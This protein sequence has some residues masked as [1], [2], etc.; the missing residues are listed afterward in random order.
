MQA[1]KDSRKTR[2]ASKKKPGKSEGKWSNL[3]ITEKHNTARRIAGILARGKASRERI[4][5]VETYSFNG[6]LVVGLSGHVVE[7]DFPAD[8]NNWQKIELRDLIHAK[9][10]VNPTQS[11]IVSVIRKLGREA[12]RVT[13]ATDFDREGELIG[14]E[15]LNIIREVNPDVKVERVRYSAIT[16]SEIERAFRNPCEVD[17]NLAAAAESRQI[18]DLVWGAVLTRFISLAAGRLGDKFLSVGR[19]QSPTLALLVK[20]EKERLAFKPEPYWEIYADLKKTGGGEF[21]AQH[22]QGRFKDQETA[23]SVL[24]KLGD[25]AVVTSIKKGQRTDQVPVPFNT[26]EFLR[27]ASSIGFSAANAMRIAESL[28]VNGYIS[29]PR[30]DNTVY[31]ESLD[32]KSILRGF[33]GTEFEGYASKLLEGEL[34]PSR[35][36]KETTDHPPIHPVTPA[37]RSKLKPDEWRIY[38]LVV[39]RFLA[40]FSRPARWETLRVTLDINGESFQASGSRLI[41]AGWREFYPYSQAKEKLLPALQEG[42]ILTVTGTELAAKETQPPPRYGQGNLIKIMEELGIGTKST[43]HEII[44]KLYSRAYVHGNPLQPTKTAIAVI[45]TLEKYAATI[46]EP[47]MTSKLEADMDKITSGEL[48]LEDVVA[49][50]RAML[51]EVFLKLQESREEIASNLRDG[52]RED[53]IIGKCSQ[54]N[55]ELIVKR[56]K[57]G[58]F[59]GCTGYPECR[60]TLPLPRG[61]QLVVTDK[62]CETHKLHHIQILNKGKRPWKLGC[63]QCNYEEWKKNNIKTDEKTKP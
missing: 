40:T 20:R 46:T 29:Y 12:E 30:T 31:P 19:V 50:S 59:I 54:C 16:P 62:K 32:V 42:E 2:G 43:R 33:Q 61:G 3:I 7:V 60:F 53:R 1:V 34:R 8:Y 45:E 51:E 28:Y 21:R 37:T 24:A 6:S 5:G 57:W 25:T 15:A 14:V 55:G 4:G 48:T 22:S 18:I 38:E 39:R 41:E 36:K 35:G 9:T 17:F 11:K 13:I 58:R 10:V 27:A 44:S 23:K 56:S 26:T 52:L 47:E 49:E 63:P